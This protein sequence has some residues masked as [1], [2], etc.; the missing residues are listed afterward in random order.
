MCQVPFLSHCDLNLVSRIIVFVSY[1]I[2]FVVGV[3]NLVC[4]CILGWGSLV[5]H[6]QVTVTLTSF[7]E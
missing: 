2:L 5:Y 3:I 1:P 7:L 4:G 6:F